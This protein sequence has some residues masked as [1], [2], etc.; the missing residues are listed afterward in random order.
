MPGV[1]K[2][3]RVPGPGFA[4]VLVDV[5]SAA[6]DRV[7]HY[8]IPP[9]LAVVAGSRVVVPLGARRVEGF[10]LGLLDAPAVEPVKDILEL[11]PEDPLQPRL[12]ELCTWLARRYGC[13][14]AEAVRCLVVA[15]SRRR[16][17]LVRP[18]PGVS[19]PG[20]LGPLQRRV[21]E[22]VA[23][24]GPL[25]IPQLAR[26]LGGADAARA[27]AA[28]ARK[29]LVELGGLALP[30]VRPRRERVYSAVA[31][32]DG[33]HGPVE[34]AGPGEAAGR[35]GP[36]QARVL[37]AL[38]EV[39]TKGGLPASA[40]EAAR[41]AGVSAGAARQALERLIDRGLVRAG[42]R[43]VERTPLRGPEGEA[44]R[45]AFGLTPEQGT[46]VD[47][48]VASMSRSDPGAFLLFGVTGSG[49]TEVYLRAMEAALDAGRTALFL[50]PEISL[51]PQVVEALQR[52]FGGRISLLH[53]GLS[54]GER[55]DQWRRASRGEARVVAGA[56]S[57]VFAP[58]KD[59]GLIVV[60][61]EHENTYKQED[62]PR[63]H[64]R[65]VALERGRLEGAPVVLGSATPSLESYHA[66][67]AGALRLLRLPGRIDGRPLPPVTLVDLREELKAGN[68]G[69]FSR[70]LLER[71]RASL[72]RG[73]QVILFLNRRGHS[74][75]V[76]CRECG[77]VMRCPQCDVSLVLH[78][79]GRLRCHYCDYD[80]PA[81]DLCPRCRGSRIRWFGVGTQ[82]VEEEWKRLFPGVGVLRL[83][84]DTT[85]RK[86]SHEAIWRA[87]SRGQAQVLV[88]TQMVAK[89]FDLPRVTLVG[90]V[91]A[92]TALNLPDFRAAERTF[93]LMTQVAGRTGRGPLG[94]E[95]VIQSY[96]PEHYSL[97]AAQ[98]QDYESF[99]SKEIEVRRELRYPP[100]SVLAL[101]QFSGESEAA[102][103]DAAGRFA[104]EVKAVSGGTEVL[105]PA[106]APLSRL[107]GR[108]R[109]QV[110]LKGRDPGSLVEVARV[111]LSATSLIAPA[112]KAALDV[113]PVSLL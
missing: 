26:R 97:Q 49:K 99:Y 73:E 44:G 65:E 23:T 2:L 91:T 22:V 66:A 67:Q 46:A 40:G 41:A 54:A 106:P 11:S 92:D 15:E 28:L 34:G 89:G 51:T 58:L 3:E 1:D 64:A 110:L 63:Y 37:R 59:L 60:D 111:A 94:G 56:R 21:W 84:V 103:A 109:W 113:D 20:D 62:S 36:V 112:V 14:L 74:T 87:F 78:S 77:W 108:F 33:A 24:E 68:R 29:G 81:P 71:A 93:Q 52:R 53:S 105:G 10:V 27:A 13:L 5:A 39:G 16:G 86:G 83:D 7:F 75:F 6:V 30:R 9:G 42:W 102:V 101:A 48:V 98:K 80:R 72:G 12:L 85:R 8:R 25:T 79:P 50:V 88:G 32:D 100:Y 19:P 95:V 55:Y 61:E 57:A 69:I 35:L 82:R 96:S 18:V 70:A 47:E 90:V 107:K 104:R 45:P 4:E 17:R 43:E 38:V 76:L 31:S